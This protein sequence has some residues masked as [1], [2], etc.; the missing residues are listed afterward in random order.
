MVVLDFF[1]VE[2]KFWFFLHHLLR[3][4]PI[5]GGGLGLGVHW[6]GEGVDGALASLGVG[7]VGVDHEGGAH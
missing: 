7:V 1:G 6:A 4:P 5:V 3:E 2:K